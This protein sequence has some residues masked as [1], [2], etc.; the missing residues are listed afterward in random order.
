[1]S[2]YKRDSERADYA[3]EFR[4]ET[5]KVEQRNG[6]KIVS[7]TSM[8]EVQAPEWTKSLIKWR[9]ADSK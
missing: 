3:C 1:M 7:H 9:C 8:A 6:Q 2:D 4:N 5:A